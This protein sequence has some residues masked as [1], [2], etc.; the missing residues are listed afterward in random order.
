MSLLGR[1][2]FFSWLIK[3]ICSK[4]VKPKAIWWGMHCLPERLGLLKRGVK[5][6]REEAIEEFRA[7]AQLYR[8]LSS[9][10]FRTVTQEEIDHM[11]QSDFAEYRKDKDESMLAQGFDDIYRYLRKRNTGTRQ[12][13]A[14]DFTA[15][16]LGTS[17]YK[18]FQAM[19]YESLYRDASGLL[20]Q[21][22]RNEVYQTF[23]YARIKLKEGLDLPDDHLSFEFEFMALLC[24]RALAALEADDLDVCLENL[25][26]QKKF[27]ELHILSW[28]ERFYTLALVLIKTRFYRGVMKITKGF[29]DTESD[30]MGTLITCVEAMAK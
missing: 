24:E 12:E 22:P 17:S 2:S 4:S 11:A 30:S 25:K 27:F 21:G 16:F 8:M 5:V 10:F 18:G 26:T 20:M 3:N 9:F 13:M 1:A 15:V 23:K 29:I 14:A 6:T 19:P 7:R 28:F